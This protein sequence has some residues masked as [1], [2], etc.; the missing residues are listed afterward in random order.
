MFEGL[1][2]FLRLNAG[3]DPKSSPFGVTY[4]TEKGLVFVYVET[5]ILA[6]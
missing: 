6:I 2:A 1:R 3:R 4:T 5:S